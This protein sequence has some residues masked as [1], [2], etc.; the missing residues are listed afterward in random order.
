[1]DALGFGYSLISL[2][3]VINNAFPGISIIRRENISPDRH[4]V[5][6]LPQMVG[7][8]DFLEPP[9]SDWHI[10]VPTPSITGR[11]T[12]G[13]GLFYIIARAE[14][15]LRN[16]IS[17]NADYNEVYGQPI[18]KGT[19]TKTDPDERDEFERQLDR[20]G[21]NPWILLDEGQDELEIIQAP[22]AGTGHQT[23][24]N[25]EKRLEQKISKVLLGHADALDSTPG[26]LGS[27]QKG[28][29]E[30]SP[31]QQAL[32]EIQ[33]K[34]G[35]FVENATNGELIPRLQRLGFPIPP[36]YHF[37]FLNNKENEEFRRKED[38]SNQMTANIALAMNQAGLQM[39]AA[40]FQD[41]T[42]IPTTKIQQPNAAGTTPKQSDLNNEEK[43]AA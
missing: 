28:G 34:D 31:Q 10:W 19:T 35:I 32:D 13:Y 42:G 6:S 5:S 36:N 30:E 15:F 4:N 29:G 2:G 27:G 23:F 3:D 12:C 11:E 16:N 24:D 14:I 26:K 20:M 38:E 7:G 18:R 8:I 37:E 25:F 9:Y 41:R 22:A 33:V 40:Y 17:F 39:D 21:A 43:T 1:L